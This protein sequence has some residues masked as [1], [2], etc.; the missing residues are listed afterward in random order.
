MIEKNEELSQ[1]KNDLITEKQNKE[2]L[3]IE[4][5]NQTIILE[6]EKQQKEQI[7]S[8]I[9]KNELFIEINLISKSYKLKKSR[10]K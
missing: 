6:T 1:K 5:T 7:V 9:K 10:I 8:K 3:F 2:Q 4:Q